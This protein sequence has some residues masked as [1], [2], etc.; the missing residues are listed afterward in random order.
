MSQ[1]LWEGNEIPTLLAPSDHSEVGDTVGACWQLATNISV[2]ND[3]TKS[4][5]FFMSLP[6]NRMNSCS[7]TVELFPSFRPF[8]AKTWEHLDSQRVGG[9]DGGI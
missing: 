7:L 8:G 3:N 2:T 4:A 9:G 1:K 6:L 5:D